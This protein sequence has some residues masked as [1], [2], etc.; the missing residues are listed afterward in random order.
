MKKS[1]IIFSISATLAGIWTTMIVKITKASGRKMNMASATKFIASMSAGVSGYKIGRKILSM[2]H[3]SQKF[4]LAMFT[5]ALS[6][7]ISSCNPAVWEALAAAIEES[8]IATASSSGNVATSAYQYTNTTGCKEI[9][10]RKSYQFIAR[11]TVNGVVT[12]K[13]YEA[14]TENYL[15]YLVEFD[16]NGQIL[17]RIDAG[18]APMPQGLDFRAELRQEMDYVYGS[19]NRLKLEQQHKMV[20][21]FFYCQPWTVELVN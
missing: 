12:V 8:Q 10:V 21:L 7:S 9:R 19:D 4:Y 11:K 5:I 17:K 13:R 1:I 3:Y 16:A 14:R 2:A 15:M 6:L 20:P 18:G